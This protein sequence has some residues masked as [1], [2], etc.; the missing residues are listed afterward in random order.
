MNVLV[1]SWTR[2][3]PG[4]TH[5]GFRNRGLCIGPLRAGHQYRFDRQDPPLSSLKRT[6]RDRAV[7]GSQL[8]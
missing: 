7:P 2:G 5:Q 8:L 3:I 4:E 6:S 1:V